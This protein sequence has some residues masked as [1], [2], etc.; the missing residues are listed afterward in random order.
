MTGSLLVFSG[1]L[2][3]WAMMLRSGVGKAGILG[4][5]LCVIA[6]TFFACGGNSSSTSVSAVTCGQ[7]SSCAQTCCAIPNTQTPPTVA[8]TCGGSCSDAG[9]AFACDGPEDCSAGQV[10]CGSV[11]MGVLEYVHCK[12]SCDDT[13]SPHLCHA[14]PDC[15]NQLPYC[16]PST[17]WTTGISYMECMA[18]DNGQ[19]CK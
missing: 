5:S 3:R 17:R 13:V 9:V 8:Y 4:T 18:A 16:C 11:L 12:A 14:K 6:Y 19:G 7:A 1:N 10:C 15:P 2:W